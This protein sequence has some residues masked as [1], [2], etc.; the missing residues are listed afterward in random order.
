MIARYKRHNLIFK[1][2]SG[3][4]RGI[5]TEK[6]TWYIIL[7]DNNKIG[8][9]ECG[10]L[11]SLSFDDRPDYEEKLQ[12]T[13]K[14]IHLGKEKLWE[15]LRDWPSIQFGVEQ[16]FLSL[17][18]KNP[19]ILFPSDFTEHKDAIAINGLVWMGEEAFMKEQIDEKL[20][21]GFNCVKLKIGA[22]DFDKELGLLQYIRK[23]F[24][25]EQIELRVDANGGFHPEEALFKLE[26]LSTLNLHSIEQPI[27]QHQQYQMAEL[28]K[29][30]PLPIALD[31][32]L[33]GVTNYT[34]K[35]ALLDKII[36]QYIILKPSLV[37]GFKGS[38]EWI[39]L[40]KERN[41]GWWIT[42]ALESNIGLN[43]IAQWT[44]TLESNMP[45]GL[46]T[47]SLYINN[48]NA[49]LVVK[50]GA[51]WYDDQIQWDH[52]ILDN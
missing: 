38:L 39:K 20:K 35:A 18:S 43:A 36:P 12:W 51:L 13:V 3:T 21:E 42:S 52:S 8:I 33:I 34:D 49:P 44:Y 45:Q 5:L 29:I 46:G 2:P 26:Q 15:E 48:I 10:I 32:E 40:A 11:R 9:G 16:A 6:E 1:R 7:E 41:I 28:C 37:G 22:I 30:T 47:G 27:K 17:E 4:S 25:A 14:N 50:N 24:S 19:F 31:E 23:H